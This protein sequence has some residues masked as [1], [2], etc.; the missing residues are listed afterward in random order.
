MIKELSGLVNSAYKYQNN[1]DRKNILAMRIKRFITR[2][3]CNKLGHTFIHIKDSDKIT[4]YG[5]IFT[6][7]CFFCDEY[8]KVFDEY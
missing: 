5:I 8:K 3:N 1:L 6:Y 2:K 4:R 7:K